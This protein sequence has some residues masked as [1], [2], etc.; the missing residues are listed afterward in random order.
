ML[1][2]HKNLTGHLHSL[3]YV[4]SEFIEIIEEVYNMT[5]NYFKLKQTKFEILKTSKG[6]TYVSKYLLKT[7]KKGE[8][9]YNYYK[10]YFNNVKFFSSSNFRNTTQEKVELVYKYLY[11]N[12]PN[13]LQRYKKSKKPLY[14]LIEQL[15]IKNIFTFEDIEKTNITINYS[16][17]KNEYKKTILLYE[18][19][20]SLEIKE[21]NTEIIKD[22]D[23][24]ID[25][26]ID[27]LEDLYF[28][29]EHIIYE[30]SKITKEN[31]IKRFKNK[32][33]NNL[34]DYINITKNKVASKMYY[35]NNLVLDKSK[36]EFIKT[37]TSELLLNPFET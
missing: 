2:P 21:D 9:F 19:D 7:T 4:A 12:N 27:R 28:T 20:K 25:I 23:I 26:T 31:Y 22:K 5:I 14:Y 16:K 37:N 24:E 6:S 33:V 3:F 1:E 18:K 10:R 15:I 8:E 29:I 32:I 17:I 34:N 13:L 30:N 11:Q 36:W 35:K